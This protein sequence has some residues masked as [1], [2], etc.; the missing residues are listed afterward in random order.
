MYLQS[1]NCTPGSNRNRI[2]ALERPGPSI[3][4]R[5]QKMQTLKLKQFQSA[6]VYQ[7]IFTKIIDC[8]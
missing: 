1:F 2:I 8:F 4:R 7:T 6:K 5:E 3:E